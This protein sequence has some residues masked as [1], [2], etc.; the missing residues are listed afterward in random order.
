MLPYFFLEGIGNIKFKITAEYDW[1]AGCYKFYDRQQQNMMISVGDYI[2][3]KYDNSG[4]IG[5]NLEATLED[6]LLAKFM[7]PSGPRQTF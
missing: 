4:W 5:I 7:H 1:Y 6:K 2:A 3:V